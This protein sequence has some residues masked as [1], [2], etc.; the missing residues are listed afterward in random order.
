MPWAQR[1]PTSG[2]AD[3]RIAFGRAIRALRLYH[4]WTQAQLE[5]RSGIDQTIISRI[6]T[7]APLGMRFTRLLVLLDA[8]GVDRIAFKTRWEGASAEASQSRGRRDFDAL[9]PERRWTGARPAWADPEDPIDPIVPI[10]GDHD[11]GQLDRMIGDGE[12]IGGGGDLWLRPIDEFGDRDN[13][14]DGLLD[15]LS[16]AV[17]RRSR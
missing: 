11:G 5:F 3:A 2:A 6:E 13:L 14:H 1:P 7:G 16:E 4:G 15:G 8:M 9:G 10:E 12:P 17:V